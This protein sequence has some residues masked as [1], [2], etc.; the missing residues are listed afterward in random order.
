LSEAARE[1]DTVARFGGDEFVVIFPRLSSA[2]DLNALCD[3]MQTL[4]SQPVALD[5]VTIDVSAS[6]GVALFDP[7]SDDARSL[8]MRADIAMYRAKRGRKAL[9]VAPDASI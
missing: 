2:D 8:L 9:A 3:K 1:E 4:L 7:A 6:L 5:D